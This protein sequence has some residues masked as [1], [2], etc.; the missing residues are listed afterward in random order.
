MKKENILDLILALGMIILLLAAFLP[1]INVLSPLTRYA[2][3]G[4]AILVTLV[5]ILQ[6]AFRRKQKF[7][8]RVRRLFT[9]EFWSAMCYMVSAF[10]LFYDPYHSTWLGFLTAGAVIQIYAAFMIDYQL[11][12]DAKQGNK[13]I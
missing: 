11:K 3:A 6:R 2:F 5:R 12:K 8:L 13:L 1:L 7:S 10:M 9:L 4:A